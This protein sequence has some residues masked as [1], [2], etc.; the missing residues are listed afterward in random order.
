MSTGTPPIQLNLGLDP[1]ALNQAVAEM[2]TKSVL[3]AEMKKHIEAA[4]S[5]ALT[6]RPYGYSSPT[7]VESVVR[8]KMTEMLNELWESEY[9]EKVRDGL[10]QQLGRDDVIDK[11]ATKSFEKLIAALDKD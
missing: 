2:I 3:G 1:E 10:R 5:N 11:L 9:K 8:S 6:S 4:I 7:L